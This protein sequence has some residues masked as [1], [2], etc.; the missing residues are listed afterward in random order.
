MV[1]VA[2]PACSLCSPRAPSLRW[3]SFFVVWTHISYLSTY[4]QADTTTGEQTLDRKE[5]TRSTFVSISR[6][7]PISIVLCLCV[8][9]SFFS[10]SLSVS[11][12]CFPC[13]LFCYFLTNKNRTEQKRKKKE[14]KWEREKETEKETLSASASL[15]LLWV[16]PFV[17]CKVS[18][19]T[20]IRLCFW[21][22][23][24]SPP[25]LRTMS[26]MSRSMASTSSWP[27]GIPL[28]RFCLHWY[29][30]WHWYGLNTIRRR[31]NTTQSDVRP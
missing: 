2:R 3:V 6:S 26:P 24:T 5:R 29:W 13:S 27:C 11:R 16:S 23:F 4:L 14:R 22:R 10:L 18:N 15:P 12:H 21:D 17:G 1:P 9:L 8:S 31:Y 20:D 28:V 19:L 30:H 25:S 7:H